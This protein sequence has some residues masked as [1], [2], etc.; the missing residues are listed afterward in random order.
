MN[1]DVKR[2][3][4][5]HK[6]DLRILEIEEEKG[7]LPSIIQDQEEQLEELKNTLDKTAV[8]IDSISKSISDNKIKSKDLLSKIDTHNSQIYSVKNNKEYEAILT[9]ID[10]LKKEN[11]E[12]EESI[13]NN[14]EQK[15]VLSKTVDE[16]KNTLE[17]LKSKLD[18]NKEEL[19]AT[20]KE[21]EEEEK[22]LSDNKES[23]LEEI[24]DKEF[25]NLYLQGKFE[26]KIGTINRDSCDTCYSFLPPQYVLNIKKMDKLYECPNCGVQLYWNE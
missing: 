6:I 8:D 21:S 14:T 17:E 11:D 25:V 13:L 23:I 7:E 22:Q 18:Q 16:V 26:N 4:D 12:I 9:E 19:K 3:I 1:L 5:I 24:E 2:I 15:E 10:F 20:S